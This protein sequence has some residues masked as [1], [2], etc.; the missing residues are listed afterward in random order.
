MT[1]TPPRTFVSRGGQKL[2]HAFSSF[3]FD[4]TGH[5]CADFGCSVGGFTDCLLQHGAASVT[6]VDTAWGILAWSLRSDDRVHVMERTNV[7][8][9]P[10]PE[11]DVSRI[12]IDAGW[13][14]QSKVLPVAMKWLSGGGEI[15]T[16]IKPH[17]E[18]AGTGH[19]ASLEKGQLSDSAAQR[20]CDLVLKQIA[21]MGIE[22]IDSA[23]SPIRGSKSS[24]R[25]AGNTEYLSHL[26]VR[27][28]ETSA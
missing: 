24:K 4:V 10:V 5:R 28:V 20:V 25:G 21:A 18:A 6:A 15:V 3:A 13:T 11:K 26:R 23:I 16:L 9:A 27:A 8:H 14:P 17:Y 2:Q 12:V 1:P 22:V 19:K 7:L